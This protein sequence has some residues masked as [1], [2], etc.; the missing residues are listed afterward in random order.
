MFAAAFSSFEEV[1]SKLDSPFYMKRTSETT[2]VMV[3]A[4]SDPHGGDIQSFKIGSGF[5][6]ADPFANY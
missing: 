2:I 5:S 1:E 6:P 3:A 4:C